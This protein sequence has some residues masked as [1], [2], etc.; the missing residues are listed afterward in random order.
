MEEAVGFVRSI[1]DA[2]GF[3][4]GWEA[5][6]ELARVLKDVEDPVKRSYLFRRLARQPFSQVKIRPI[7]MANGT[8]VENVLQSY[9]RQKT[10][11]K[12]LGVL[13]CS[14][15]IKGQ[16]FL[17]IE[18]HFSALLQSRY[19]S[20]GYFL[21]ASGYGRNYKEEPLI[22]EAKDI[23]Y[24]SREHKIIVDRLR[25][26][27]SE[28]VGFYVTLGESLYCPHHSTVK[29]SEATK[30]DPSDI[31][32]FSHAW[33][34]DNKKG[35]ADDIISGEILSKESQDNSQMSFQ[36]NPTFAA[37]SYPTYDKRT[38]G[39]IHY[40]GGFVS[41]KDCFTEEDIEDTFG[42][43]NEAFKKSWAHDQNDR[44]YSS[45]YVLSFAKRLEA[46]IAGYENRIRKAHSVFV[47]ATENILTIDE[48][49]RGIRKIK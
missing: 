9:S 15:Y 10:A 36:L 17:K 3:M 1:E 40:I 25:L 24:N 11:F 28:C 29:K 26:L 7:F 47:A 2:G 34:T 43:V 12:T 16:P 35:E 33:K 32:K 38:I 14:S 37:Q 45:A 39:G 41:L 49:W 4:E 42:Y 22:R 48:M 19:D 18:A 20:Y 8:D 13:G 5:E 27:I 30:K 31:I 44:F 21:S 46:R 23:T 6:N